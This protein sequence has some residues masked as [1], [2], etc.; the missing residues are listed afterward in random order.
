[1]ARVGFAVNLLVRRRFADTV[2]LRRVISFHCDVLADGFLGDDD[3][4]DYADEDAGVSF[5]PMKS[6]HLELCHAHRESD[7][8][9]LGGSC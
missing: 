7:G 8:E 6:Q 3:D 1:M 5:D 9:M 4:R 2:I